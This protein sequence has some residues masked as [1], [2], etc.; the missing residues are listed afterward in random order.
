[1]PPNGK[2]DSGSLRPIVMSLLSL[3]AVQ[4]VLG[5]YANL[6]V[7][8]PKAGAVVS[9]MGDMNVV[10]DHVGLLLHMA[11]GFVLALTGIAA[12]IMAIRSA[13]N[14]AVWLAGLGLAALILAGIG[15]MAFV[16]LGQSNAYSYLMAIGFL[17]SFSCYFAELSVTAK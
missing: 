3:L 7:S 13:N 16:M 17:V 12:L 5:I 15:G 8:F 11:L 9:M 10:M 2:S 6:D 14:K 4:F 1:M